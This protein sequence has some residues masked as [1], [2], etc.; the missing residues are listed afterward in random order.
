[1]ITRMIIMIHFDLDLVSVI[2]TVAIFNALCI[3]F[4]LNIKLC[5]KYAEFL[6]SPVDLVP[7][8]NIAQPNH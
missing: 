6:L 8:L 2:A 3:S 1:M 4:K 5:I 7:I